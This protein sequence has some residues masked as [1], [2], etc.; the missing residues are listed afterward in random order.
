M[1]V[2]QGEPRRNNR[3]DS[4]FFSEILK[5]KKPDQPGINNRTRER[6]LEVKNRVH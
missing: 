5:R 3:F 4:P 2:S 1:T 6:C